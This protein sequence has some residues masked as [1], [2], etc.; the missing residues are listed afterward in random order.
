MLRDCTSES[1][2]IS[3]SRSGRVLSQTVFSSEH[4]TDKTTCLSGQVAI[5][6]MALTP[7][8]GRMPAHI[9]T[10]LIVGRQWLRTRRH[11]HGLACEGEQQTQD[12]SPVALKLLCRGYGRVAPYAALPYRIGDLVLAGWHFGQGELGEEEQ[13]NQR[14]DDFLCKR[15]RSL[16]F[17]LLLR[18]RLLRVCFVEYDLAAHLAPPTALPPRGPEEVVFPL[19]EAVFLIQE[20]QQAG[21]YANAVEGITLRGK[22]GVGE[23]GVVAQDIE[24][25]GEGEDQGLKVG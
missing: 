7:F 23:R 1:A 21:E 14:V 12:L 15:L 11:V 5:Y 20:R 3:R 24:A 18:R 10:A 22:L 9:S 19:L 17:G 8:T 2:Q 4:R 13:V 25:R 6:V 16:V